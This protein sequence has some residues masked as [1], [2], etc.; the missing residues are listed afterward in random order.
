MIDEVTPT[1]L[2]L[3]SRPAHIKDDYITSMVQHLAL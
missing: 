2:A 3:T 1:L